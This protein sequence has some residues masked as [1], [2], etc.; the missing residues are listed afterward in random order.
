MTTLQ[1]GR[2]TLRPLIG[3]DSEAYAAMR[4]HPEVAKWLRPEDG[5][6]VELARASIERFRISWQERRCAPW[7]LFQDGRLIGHGGLN[8]VPE[9]GET[10]VLWALHPDAWKQGYA[11]EMAR[12]ALDYGFGELGLEL[13]FAM[14]KPD[15][16]PSQA[17]MRR[18]GMAY[19]KNVTYRGFDM[20]WLD[21]SREKWTVAWKQ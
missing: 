14:T 15:N 11:T 5:D 19:R 2:L 9:F 17:V 3:S 16:G 6:P 10:E 13:I 21:I 7:G 1:T 18:L 4:Y 12:A 8:F 20:V